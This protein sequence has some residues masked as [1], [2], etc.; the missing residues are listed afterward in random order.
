MSENDNPLS[1]VEPVSGED[2][3]VRPRVGDWIQTF[4]GVEVYPFDP[5]PE[6]IRIEDIAHALSMQC[7][8]AG[9]CSQFYS[10]AEHSVRVAELLPREV[11]LWGLLHDASEAYLVDLPRPIKRHSEIGALYRV[12]EESLMRAIAARF[13]L[14]WPEPPLIDGADKAMLCWEAM[15]LLPNNTW[16]KKWQHHLT[17]RERHIA[18]TETPARA[19]SLFLTAFENLTRDRTPRRGVE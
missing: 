2:A 7:R 15:F 13:D 9:H 12:A 10:V 11:Q 8:Y 14:E 4:T 16:H 5:R 6:D 1:A 18:F 19:E 3:G 17:G